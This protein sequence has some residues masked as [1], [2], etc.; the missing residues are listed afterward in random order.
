[1]SSSQTSAGEESGLGSERELQRRLSLATPADTVRGFAL[2]TVL[3]AV[4]EELG[5]EAVERCL[6][7]CSEKSFRSFYFY[8]VSDYL[9]VLYTGAWM[10]SSASGGFD[11][12]VRH[13]RKG[14]APGFLSSVVGKAFL[15][16]GIGPRQIINNLPMAFRATASFGESEVRWTGP[17]SGILLTKRDF[18]L[19]LNHE[20]GL[21]S[22]FRSL[23]LSGAWT[24]G[25]QTGPLDNEVE[26]SWE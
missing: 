26:F 18:L 24:R 13:M 12:A 7:P 23:G 25:R 17:R 10:L 8:P 6:E 5:D 22:L 20:G 3:Q 1:M 16:S 11:N 21:Q 2:N 19:Y 4:R 9:R 14:L 15:L